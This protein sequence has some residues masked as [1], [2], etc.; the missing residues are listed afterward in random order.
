MDFT[1]VDELADHRRRAREWVAAHVTA[2]M[3][4]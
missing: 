3:V 2:D 1:V 4:A